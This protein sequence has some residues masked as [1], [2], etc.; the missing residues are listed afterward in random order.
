MVYKISPNRESTCIC[1]AVGT[2]SACKKLEINISQVCDH[3][4]A[5]AIRKRN[6]EEAHK[7]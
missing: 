4:L 6:E 5:V 3:A 1:L 2:V 7:K